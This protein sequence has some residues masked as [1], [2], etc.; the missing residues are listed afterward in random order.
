MIRNRKVLAIIPAR[1]GSKGLP[2]KNITFLCN[3]PLINHTIEQALL[4]QYIDNVMVTT[5]DIEIAEIAEIAGAEIPFLRKSSLATDS[6]ST[7][8]VIIDCLNWYRNIGVL[9]EYFILLQPTSPLRTIEDINNAFELL[10]TKKAK[11]IVSVCESDHHPYW[12]NILPADQNMHSFENPKY[13]NL[14][15]Q[16]LP[17]Y[18]RQN[19]AIYLAEVKYF[20]KLES[21]I[22]N[23]TYAQIMNKMHSID[24]DDILDLKFAEF[25][26]NEKND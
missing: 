4:C 19:G 17:M 7:Y 23:K 6:A 15:R 8:D 14:G 2:R 9:Y 22:G 26:L 16:E 11:S 21:F 10:K 5:D 24:I 18:Y 12:M 1:G 13:A 20:S 25:L 3:K